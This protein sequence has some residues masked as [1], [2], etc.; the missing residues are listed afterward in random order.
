MENS[1]FVMTD[2]ELKIL[3][4]SIERV[5]KLEIFNENKGK[6]KSFKKAA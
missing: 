3:K 5:K 1:K 4:K 6:K 2:E